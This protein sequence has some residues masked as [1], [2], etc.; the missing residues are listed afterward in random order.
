VSAPYTIVRQDAQGNV[1][2]VTTTVDPFRT[3]TRFIKESEDNWVLSV[4]AAGIKVY[5]VTT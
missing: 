2:T 4:W 3:L 5:E 1:V